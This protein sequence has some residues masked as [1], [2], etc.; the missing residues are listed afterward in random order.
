MERSEMNGK[1][2]GI[3]EFRGKFSLICLEFL[4]KIRTFVS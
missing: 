2:K 3:S 4:E 1:S